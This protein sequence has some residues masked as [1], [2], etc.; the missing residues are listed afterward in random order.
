MRSPWPVAAAAPAR[1]A[2]NSCSL[3][4]RQFPSPRSKFSASENC[5]FPHPAQAQVAR[6]RVADLS[7]PVMHDA[8]NDQLFRPVSF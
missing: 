4:M 5:T 7:Q 3:T 1:P 8:M 2:M 6:A